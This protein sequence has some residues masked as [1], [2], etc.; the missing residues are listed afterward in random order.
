VDV[1][2]N[3]LPRGGEKQKLEETEAQ[4]VGYLRRNGG[5]VV[6][7]SRGWT[8]RTISSPEE[9]GLEI[10]QR[11]CPRLEGVSSDAGGAR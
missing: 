2:A 4:I 5:A 10:H 1:K 11:A 8:E 7:F 9:S 3:R 6:G